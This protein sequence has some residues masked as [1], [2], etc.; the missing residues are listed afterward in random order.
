MS[1]DTPDPLPDDIRALLRDER[2]RPLDPDINADALFDAISK[3][4]SL[5]TLTPSAPHPSTQ[6]P[7]GPV[8]IGATGAG[9][10]AGKVGA[11]ALAFALGAG[12]GAVGDRWI[13]PAVIVERVVRVPVERPVEVRV[14][15]PVARVE[16]VVDAGTVV[17]VATE[18]APTVSSTNEVHH[19][20]ERSTRTLDDEIALIDQATA[21]LARGNAAAAL[22]SVR[23]HAR[24]FPSGAMN[25][26]RDRLWI[27]ALVRTGRTDEARTRATAFARRFPDSVHRAA[28]ERQLARD[29]AP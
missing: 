15:V 19:E 2:S 11:W 26:D 25:E 9:F 22:S 1:T 4:I 28:I 24:R 3:E 18:V 7:P 6:P 17:P 16:S 12:A 20:R 27:D 8:G 21:A 5:P 13:R 23:E 14:E 10:G 29:A